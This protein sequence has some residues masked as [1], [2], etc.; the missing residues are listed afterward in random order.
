[1]HGERVDGFELL[2]E[3]SDAG[4]GERLLDPRAVHGVGGGILE[5]SP[6]RVD[7][8]AKRGVRRHRLY[9]DFVRG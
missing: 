9:H 4:E 3:G 1:M 2:D 7:K 5:Y 6:A 8:L